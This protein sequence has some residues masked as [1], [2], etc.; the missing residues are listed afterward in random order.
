MTGIFWK[1]NSNQLSHSQR[2][3]AIWIR[4]EL[5]ESK[6]S[7]KEILE[8]S[9]CWLNDNLMDAKGQKLICKALGSLE[10]YQFT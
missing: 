3:P 7:D 5:Y 10:T 6:E 2:T 9:N 4:N 1:I 8:G